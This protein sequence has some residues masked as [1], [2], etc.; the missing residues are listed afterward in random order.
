MVRFY[1]LDQFEFSYTSCSQCTFK[2]YVT[3]LTSV[4]KKK[5]KS[6][7]CD[8]GENPTKSRSPDHMKAKKKKLQKSGEQSKT[9]EKKKSKFVKPAKLKS[10]GALNA[11]DV[12][13]DSLRS[14]LLEK[15]ALD[16]ST[17]SMDKDTSTEDISHTE[18][19]NTS[20]EAS[21]QPPVDKETANDPK[22]SLDNKRTPPLKPKKKKWCKASK[23][24]SATNDSTK[25]MMAVVKPKKFELTLPTSKKN[26][27][28]DEKKVKKVKKTCSPKRS[29][30]EKTGTPRQECGKKIQLGHIYHF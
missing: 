7:P 12:S 4:P 27:P 28:T 15:L 23:D 30:K 5:S 9:S 18:K 2:L 29:G 22:E 3:G 8:D 25:T 13:D 26:K 17:D 6:I 20:L 21:H 14:R 24:K 16:T 11:S 10:E 1:S 19:P